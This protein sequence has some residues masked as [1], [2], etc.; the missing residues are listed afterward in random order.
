[1]KLVRHSG[2]TIGYGT[3]RMRETAL[4][5]HVD[6]SL[7]TVNLCLGSP[8]FTGS[9]IL[10]TGAQAVCLPAVARSQ[11]RR[12]LLRRLAEVEVAAVPRPGWALLHLGRHPHRTLP[13]ESGERS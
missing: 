12:D 6:D 5:L 4:R 13:I 7:L 10:F 2:H 8:G 9:A 3:G 11:A 1:M